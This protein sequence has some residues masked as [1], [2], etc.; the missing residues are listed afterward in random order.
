MSGVEVVHW[1]PPRVSGRFGRLMVP[2]FGRVDNFGDLLGPAIVSKILADRG[3]VER[4]GRRRLLSVGSI[5]KLAKPGDVVWGTGVN[6]KSLDVR[7]NCSDLDVRAVRGPLSAEWLRA[8]GAR[9]PTVYGDPGLLSA[10]LWPGE[11]S[12]SRNYTIVPNLHD[13]AAY[14]DDPHAISPLM[15]FWAIRERILDSQLVVGSSL[16]GIVVAEAY[17]I[18]ARLIV[19]SQEPEFKYRD[20]YLG[21]GRSSCSFAGDVAE[22][23]AL[24]GERPPA[25]DA[26]GLLGSFPTDLWRALE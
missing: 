7:L 10:H 22:A 4:E 13:A 9:V 15:P 6:G 25:W 5:M 19:S 20:Y 21:T 11:P 26:A 2:I 16:H 3:L 24:G 23:I 8:R 14:V 1:N 17:G 12:G 18:P